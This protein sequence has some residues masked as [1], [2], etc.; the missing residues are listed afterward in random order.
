MATLTADRLVI[1]LSWAVFLAIF[2]LVAVQA[3]RRPSRA[4]IDIALLFERFHRGTN[5]DDRRFPGMGLGLFICKGIAEQHGGQIE[6]SSRAGEGST[7]RV[8]LP[9]APV[10]VGEYAA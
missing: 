7:F 10:Q 2:G 8:C 3:I 6:A 5:E 4:H 9:L 1:Y